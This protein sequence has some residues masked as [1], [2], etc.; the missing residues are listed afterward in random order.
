[1]DAMLAGIEQW[2]HRH[3]GQWTPVSTPGQYHMTDPTTG[4]RLLGWSASLAP[5]AASRGRL[6]PTCQNGLMQDAVRHEPRPCVFA[7]GG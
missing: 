2:N 6:D 4:R 5:P 7:R 1:M 3:P